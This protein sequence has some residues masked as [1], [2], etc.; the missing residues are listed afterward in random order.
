M[1]KLKLQ[2]ENG[3]QGQTGDKTQDDLKDKSNIKTKVGAIV[4]FCFPRVD[5]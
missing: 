5:L 3:L 1:A 4:L 2:L